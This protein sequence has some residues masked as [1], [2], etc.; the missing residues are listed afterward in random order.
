MKSLQECLNWEKPQNS[1]AD[2]YEVLTTIGVQP[3]VIKLNQ[4]ET[5]D[6]HV[7]WRMERITVRKE[8][9]RK[10]QKKR[11]E[12]EERIQALRKKE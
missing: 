12:E 6:E 5:V 11:Q 8:L 7:E 2:Q 4:L 9:E 3:D 10:E 1:I